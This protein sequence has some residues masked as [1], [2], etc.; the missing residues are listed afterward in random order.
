MSIEEKQQLAMSKELLILLEDYN[1][2]LHEGNLQSEKYVNQ[3]IYQ[4]KRII[5]ITE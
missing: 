1:D 5:E 3:I 2:I 4:C